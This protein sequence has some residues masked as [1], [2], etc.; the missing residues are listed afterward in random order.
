MEV[1]RLATECPHCHERAFKVVCFKNGGPVMSVIEVQHR[2][3]IESDSISL[4]SS[5]IPV[6]YKRCLNCGFMA[7]FQAVVVDRNGH[8]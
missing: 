5:G 7:P 2:E 3:D 1:L 4:G 8:L 6:Y